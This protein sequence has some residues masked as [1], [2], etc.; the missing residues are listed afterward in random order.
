MARAAAGSFRVAEDF[1]LQKY[2]CTRLFHYYQLGGMLQHALR[3]FGEKWT[4]ESR[5][6]RAGVHSS[7]LDHAQ[8]GMQSVQARGLVIAEWTFPPCDIERTR[9]RGTI[10]TYIIFH[11]TSLMIM[12]SR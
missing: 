5:R 7:F 6:P 10:E 9:P 4:G 12:L 8:P 3:K 2:Y 11:G 1:V